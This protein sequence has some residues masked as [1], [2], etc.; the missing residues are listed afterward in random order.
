MFLNF[1]LYNYSLEHAPSEYWC[2]KGVF[3]SQLHRVGR[4]SDIVND[5]IQYNHRY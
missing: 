5:Y 2:Q 1:M 4:W 3:S